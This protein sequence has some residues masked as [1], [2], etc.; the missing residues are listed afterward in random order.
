LIDEAKD[1]VK[2]CQV[3]DALLG[4]SHLYDD[5]VVALVKFAKAEGFGKVVITHANWT[6]IRGHKP[7]ELKELMAMGAWLEFCGTCM[8][9]PY[10]CLTVEEEVRWLNELG[11]SRTYLA[12]DAGAQIFGTVPSMFRAYLQHL[13]NTGLPLPAIKTMAIDNPKRLL[14]MA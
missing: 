3:W 13:N 10:C 14:H 5:E 12:T 8:L 6:I 9:P 7:N 4:I 1:V 11:T 2:I